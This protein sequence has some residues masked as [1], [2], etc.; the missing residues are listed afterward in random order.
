MNCE[1]Q[2]QLPD[3]FQIC[4]NL[5]VGKSAIAFRWRVVKGFVF[6]CNQSLLVTGG[7]HTN[8]NLYSQGKTR[9]KDREK[10]I[11]SD[12]LSLSVPGLK[13]IHEFL[14]VELITCIFF[15]IASENLELHQY[16]FV[17]LMIFIIL[18]AHLLVNV[19]IV[20]GEVI[21]IVIW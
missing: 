5:A 17:K 8:I 7:Y 13:W 19:M 11:D 20:Q 4:E 16:L 12:S 2:Y 14:L 6:L 15:I 9:P 10:V 18:I 1:Y 21:N 3:S